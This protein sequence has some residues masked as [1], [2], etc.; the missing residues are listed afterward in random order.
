MCVL[1]VTYAY[2][3]HYYVNAMSGLHVLLSLLEARGFDFACVFS[4]IDNTLSFNI[5][6]G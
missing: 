6:F 1:N 5:Y 4:T 2:A 3:Q